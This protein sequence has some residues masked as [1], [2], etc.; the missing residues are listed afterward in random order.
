MRISNATALSIILLEALGVLF[1]VGAVRHSTSGFVTNRSS[2]LSS[3]VGFQNKPNVILL[4]STNKKHTETKSE[5]LSEKSLEYRRRDILNLLLVSSIYSSNNSNAFSFGGGS[6]EPK[7]IKPTVAS[8]ITGSP[9]FAQ[10]YLSKKGAGDYTMVQGL[11]GDPTYLLVKSDGSSLESYALN[12]ECTHLGCVVPWDNVQKKFIC[13]CHG[14]QYDR[15]GN[16]LRGPAPGPLKLAKVDIEEESGKV[17]LLPW[18]E[19]DFRSGEKPWW[20]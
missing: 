19:D 10:A 6:G 7:E 17:L 2:S 20:I 18:A 13:P 1:H 14:S 4:Y 5:S 12:A 16:V 11:K 15:M 9:I 8:D 3:P